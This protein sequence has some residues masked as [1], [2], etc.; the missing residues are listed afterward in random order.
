MKQLLFL[1]LLLSNLISPFP[2]KVD[3]WAWIGFNYDQYVPLNIVGTVQFKGVLDENLL[4]QSLF[5]MQER[6]PSLACSAYYD[7]ASRDWILQKSDQKIP[8]HITV[9]TSDTHWQSIMSDELDNKLPI[10][11]GPFARVTYCKGGDRGELIVTMHHSLSDGMSRTYFMFELFQLMDD[12]KNDRSI[13]TIADHFLDINY[14]DLYNDLQNDNFVQRSINANPK[15]VSDYKVFFIPF[16]FSK[17][18]TEIIQNKYRACGSSLQTILSAAVA[19]AVACNRAKR[20]DQS[21]FKIFCHNPINIRSNFKCAVLTGHD[22]GDWVSG[23][24]TEHTIDAH[25]DIIQLSKEIKQQLYAG[26]EE[27]KHLYFLQNM[28]RFITTTHFSCQQIFHTAQV[29]HPTATVSQLGILDFSAT[30]GDIIVERIAGLFNW[31]GC[32]V[33]EDT[34][35]MTGAIFQNQ[36]MGMFACIEPIVSREQAHEMAETVKKLLL[37]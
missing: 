15:D 34:F 35:I 28:D 19:K 23:V 10:S 36:L 26:I 25:V 14:Y 33:H 7:P 13:E 3:C 11:D 1:V 2:K 21:P 29:D 32:F 27:K 9:R 24:N 37:S 8:L 22:F 5:I 18:E 17:E 4:R 12:L 16:C 20:G 30:Y 31:R 6:H